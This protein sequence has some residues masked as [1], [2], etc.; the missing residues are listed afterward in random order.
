MGKPFKKEL[1]IVNNTYSWAKEIDISVLREECEEFK[2]R[3]TFVVGS[4]GSI[5]SCH[6]LV[7]LQQSNGSFSKAVTPLE[8]FYLSNTIR[9][10]NVFFLSA[11]GRNSD[12]MFAQN[13]AVKHNPKNI[14]GL[15]L[16]K[17]SKLKQASLKHSLGA[18][19]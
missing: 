12:I 17:N 1:E 14:S 13:H 15:V 6:M 11:S 9:N 8:L 7:I 5:S 2:E 18:N 3:P 4:G 16:I 19:F 10:S